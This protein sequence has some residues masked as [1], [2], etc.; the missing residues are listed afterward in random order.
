MNYTTKKILLITFVMVTLIPFAIIVG[1]YYGLKT[2]LKEAKNYI[3][4]T[5]DDT[6]NYDK[7]FK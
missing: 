7:Y 2:F 6:V 1:L 5:I 3:V 4:S